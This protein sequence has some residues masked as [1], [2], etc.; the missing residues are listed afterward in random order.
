MKKIIL[1]NKKIIRNILTV[2]ITT[3][4]SVNLIYTEV[5]GRNYYIKIEASE[6]N[7][8]TASKNDTIIYFYKENCSP[9]SKFKITLNNYI[10]KNNTKVYGVN[11]NKGRNGNFDLTDKY[12]LK[13]T[14]TVIKFKSKKEIKRIEGLVSNKKFLDFMKN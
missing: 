9:C 13:Y 3:L 12:K 2:L 5:N 8:Y 7:E 6:I 14:P 1:K 4:I 10:K 11:I